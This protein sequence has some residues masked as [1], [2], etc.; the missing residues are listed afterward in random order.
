MISMNQ[1]W[2]DS[3]AFIRREAALLIPLALA[4]LYVG[5][6][7][8]NLA[9]GL[10]TPTKPNPVATVAILVATVWSI[11]GQLSIVSLVLKPGQSVGEALAHGGARLGK[12]ILIALL[13]G[14]IVALALTPIGAI[15]IANGANPAVPESFQKL[16]GWLFIL[17]LVILGAVIWLGI[18]LA[19]MNALIVDRNPRVWESLKG[20]FALTRGIAARLCLVILLYALMLLVLGSAVKFVAGSLFALIASGLGSPFAGSVM[21]ALVG[22]IVNSGLALIATVFLAILYARVQNRDLGRTFS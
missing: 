19:L 10:S 18:R 21:T 8:A 7:V 17:L 14:L 22:G 5:D 2:D 3:I 1:I 15:A 20:G 13:L 11:V 9:Q 4:T 6:V 12:V 16:P